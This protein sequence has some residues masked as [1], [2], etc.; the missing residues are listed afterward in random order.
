ML[1]CATYGRGQAYYLYIRGTNSPFPG[2]SVS[3]KNKWAVLFLLSRGAGTRGWG[4]AL[5]SAWLV[6]V[7][8][9][10]PLLLIPGA[11][12]EGLQVPNGRKESC[13][14]LEGL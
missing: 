6:G 10:A 12:G 13:S 1:G 3:D 2:K 5:L 11:V 14:A 8:G 4:T 9:L 7:S